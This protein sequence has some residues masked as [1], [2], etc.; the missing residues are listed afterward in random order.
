MNKIILLTK[1]ELIINF[2]SADNLILNIFFFVLS[3]FIFLLSFGY[4]NDFSKSSGHAIVW[5][6]ILFT[7]ILSTEQFFLEDF[8]D[9][10]IKELQILGFSSNIIISAKL[11]V[12][13]ILLIIPILLTTPI[14]SLLLGLNFIE[15]KVLLISIALGTP[16]LLL[17]SIIGIIITM[18]SKANKLLIVIL[19][20]PFYIPILIF[21][22]GSVDLAKQLMSPANNFFILIGI[23]LITLPSTLITG[24]Y[25]FREINK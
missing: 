20:F 4:D 3:I 23:F 21:G 13:W 17:V 5:S 6:V 25:A 15:I 1:R 10:G 24:K 22:V 18:Q 12:M 2:K 19:I 11:L 14:L 16:S 8:W 7:I 9:G